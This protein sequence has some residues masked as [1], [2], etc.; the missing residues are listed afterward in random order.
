M[1]AT[2]ASDNNNACGSL[3]DGVDLGLSFSS[4]DVELASQELGNGSTNLYYAK[5]KLT[6]GF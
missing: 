6:V 2:P 4:S 5:T 3:G 1:F